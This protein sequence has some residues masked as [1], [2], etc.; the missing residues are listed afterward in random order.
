MT[1]DL[2]YPYRSKPAGAPELARVLVGEREIQHRVAELGREISAH[3]ENRH[4]LAIGVLNGAVVFMADLVR[5]ISVPVDFEFMAVSSYGNST[6]SSG[7]VR[8]IK[9]L[10]TSIAG[11][12]VLIVEDIVD[13]GLTLSYLRDL[14]ISR[15]PADVRIAALFRKD[16]EDAREVPIDWIGFDIPD[17]FVVG[18]GL[19]VAGWYRNLTFLATVAVDE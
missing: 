1:A 12:D 17:E 18:Y 14:L 2:D 16:R 5:A 10:D 7:V 15:S 19:D 6:V 3:Y 4:P 8:I 11:R 13:S 9:D